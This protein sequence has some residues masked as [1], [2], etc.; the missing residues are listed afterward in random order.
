MT[1]NKRLIIKGT[2]TYVEVP[3]R[4]LSCLIFA[5]YFEQV[6][7][8]IYILSRFFVFHFVIGK[9]SLVFII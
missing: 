9:K 6:N 7:L 5:I 4:L 8:L 1:R 3:Y 2:Y